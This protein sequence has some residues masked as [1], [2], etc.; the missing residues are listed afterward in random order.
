MN[1][2][3]AHSSRGVAER[4]D[5]GKKK[6]H[7]L[8]VKSVF[9]KIKTITDAMNEDRV[10][11]YAAQ[12]SFFILI[13]VVPLLFLTLSICNYIVP[14]APEELLDSLIKLVP[15]KY[16]DFFLTVTREVYNTSSISFISITAVS[17]FWSASRGVKAVYHGIAC[18]YDKYPR[19]NI[20]YDILRSFLYTVTFIALMLISLIV[21]VF[22]SKINRF[23]QT[24]IPQITFVTNIIVRGRIIWFIV[25]ITVFFAVIY[26]AVARSG[27]VFGRKNYVNSKVAPKGFRNQLPGAAFAAAGWLMFSYAYS[28][29]FTF[30][31]TA[32]YIYGSLG[33]IV[34]LM[35]W[36]Y[37]CMIIMLLGAEINKFIANP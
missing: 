8:S 1:A 7:V 15:E 22:G 26:G 5:M 33:A 9:L 19:G 10:S 12:A 28:L 20:L 37:S 14:T 21:L 3:C 32:Y 24:N 6:S 17:A 27:K 36:I 31:P 2:V 34:F 11:V 18:V 13:S 25:F 4:R 16:S 30:F 23:I 35:L 29:Y